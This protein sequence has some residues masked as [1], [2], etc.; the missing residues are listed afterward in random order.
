MTYDQ[1]SKADPDAVLIRAEALTP[2]PTAR[3]LG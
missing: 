2:R 1:P 3:E